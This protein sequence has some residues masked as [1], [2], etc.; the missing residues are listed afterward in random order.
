MKK[1]SWGLFFL[2]I[3]MLIVSTGL[4]VYLFHL[5]PTKLGS[6]VS[7]FL[8]EKTNLEFNIESVEFS[9]A[10]SPAVVVN[11]AKFYDNS[12][13]TSINIKKVKG[14]LSWRSFLA[15][16][17]VVKQ[18]EIF[19]PD[20]HF[21]FPERKEK[22]EAVNIR[23]LSLEAARKMYDYLQ[24]FSI[25]HYFDSIRI[26]V[27]SADGE[28]VDPYSGCTYF[29]EE[30]N[31]SAKAPNIIDGYADIDLKRFDLIY[32]NSPLLQITETKISA[33]DVSY[34]PR[35][36][37]GHLSV[38]GNVQAASLQRF[39]DTPITPAYNYFP[40]PKPSAVHLETDFDIAIRSKE[41]RLQ[42]FLKN[43][44]VFPMNGHNTPFKLHIPFQ[45]TSTFEK[46]NK[47][48]LNFPH[49]DNSAYKEAFLKENTL[50]D[51]ALDLP[52]FYINEIKIENAKIF[53]D[54][55]SLDFNG[56]LTG[57]YPFNPLIFGKAKVHNFSLP[58]WIGPTRNMS[59]GLYNALNEIKAEIDVFCTMKGVFSPKLTAR[60]L[61]YDVQ[62][63][64]VTANFLK[65][66]ICFDLQLFSQENN[67]LDLNPLFPE[68]N[69]KNL[70][71][72]KLPPPA[73]TESSSSSS[74]KNKISVDY[75]INIS[76]PKSAHIWKIDCS[77][78]KVL[79]SPDKNET[80]T[81]AVDIKN[82]YTGKAAALATLYSDKKHK[83][84]AKINSVLLEAP[85]RNILGYTAGTGHADAKLILYL[86]GENAAE[87]LNSLEIYGSADIRKGALHTKEHMLTEF[88]KLYADV[89]LRAVP[90]KTDKGMPKSFA[91]TGNWLFEGEFPEYAVKLSSRKTN[92]HFSTESG[93]PLFRSPQTTQILLTERADNAVVLNGNGKLGFNLDKNSLTVEQY[94]GMLRH[95]KLIA[96]LEYTQKNKACYTGKLYFQHFD[97][98]D[99]IKQ[100]SSKKQEDK[101][102]PLDFICSSEMDLDIKAD[103][104]TFYDIT[105]RNFT[106]NIK[107]KDNKIS[108]NNL[109]TN[110]RNGIIQALL[111]GS[112]S[113]NKTRYTMLTRFKLKAEN[114]DMLSITRMRNQKT[115]MAGTGNIGIQGTAS[116]SRTSDI[117][118]TMNADWNMSFVRGYFQSKKENQGTD[119]PTNDDVKYSGKTHYNNLS[120]AGTVKNGLVE[121][122][123][124]ILHGKG[125]DIL[126]GGTVNLVTETINAYARANY[127][128]LSDIPIV[129]K[130]T[131]EKPE[132]EVKVL[133]AVSKNLG[134]LGT[135]I[136]DIFSNMII[137]PFKIFMQ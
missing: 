97:L 132:Y 108:V 11:N 100:N 130:G 124:I 87:I 53:A 96:D 52:G 64:S 69:G 56:A 122:H 37:S 60:V 86:Q 35:S 110:S 115:L 80:P 85:L 30:L 129:I 83:I 63:K 38:Q 12:L 111:E 120:A 9:L 22:K 33:R 104:L 43:E 72:A 79:V 5:Q 47:S 82:L 126:A 123:N 76:V 4:Y 21:V 51:Y 103:R 13:K 7:A 119:E 29:F 32:K 16:K 81:V 74:K 112:V 49:N 24:E 48:S 34:S 84:A 28:L 15:L 114:L 95:S 128:G 31:I 18:L 99:Y 77:D 41:I 137:Q 94:K 102:L 14:V 1:F 59:A 125:L 61:N 113:K 62:G 136:F 19:E 67:A 70:Q 10:P 66:D 25:P 23:K 93:Q 131:I 75:H 133:N 127:L 71:K 3:W 91:L 54:A 58:R 26:S 42:G 36:Y 121:T 73:V 27:H 105:T 117:F 6:T 50:N 118:K 89:S 90:F 98:S 68:I 2:I 109:K 134:N 45:L 20:V 101:E 78:V 44:T 17:P 106:G 57:L 116:I 40:M 65:P 88:D 135:G 39:Y 92:M 8:K 46:E 55:D 107:I